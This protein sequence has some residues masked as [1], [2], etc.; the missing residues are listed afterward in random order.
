MS[1]QA[2]KCLNL[3]SR[4][5]MIP[6]VLETRRRRT[7]SGGKLAETLVLSEFSRSLSPFLASFHPSLAG[8]QRVKEKFLK[9]VR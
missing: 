1:M 3:S 9:F 2:E 8:L 4:I 5:S 7:E 6:Q